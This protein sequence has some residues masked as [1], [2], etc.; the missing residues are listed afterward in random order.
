ML[1][2]QGGVVVF[3]VLFHCGLAVL[4]EVLKEECTLD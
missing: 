1:T 2:L 4:L 3:N